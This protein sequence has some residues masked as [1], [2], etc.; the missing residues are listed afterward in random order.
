M[1]AVFSSE[2]ASLLT[3]LRPDHFIV[4]SKVKNSIISNLNIKNWPVHCFDVTGC[5][6]VT[7]SGLTLDNSDG[8][9]ANS[10]SD[11]DPAAHNSDGFDFSSS[12]NIYL[13]DT[14]V[15]NQDDCV[16][17]TSGV[18]VTV[19]NMVCS[20]GHGLSIGSI[21]GKSN[22]V[23]DGVTFQN[24]VIKNSQNGC[25]IKTNSGTTGSVSHIILNYHGVKLIVRRFR[26]SYTA[27]LLFQAL[28]STELMSSKITLTG[29]LL[30][31]Q[32]MVSL[33]AASHLK[34]SQAHVRQVVRTITFSVGLV[35]ARTLRSLES[36]LREA[37]L[38]AAA[39]THRLLVHRQQ[40]VSRRNYVYLVS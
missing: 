1:S 22:N 20:G 31:H 21:G 13:T 39:T 36:A 28:L 34:R 29:G 8:D 6:T 38:Q 24:S 18:N 7:F 15:T 30:A 14:T 26:M 40:R 33:L 2:T 9:A 12:N 4:V 17:V 16:A 27:I 32:Q 23:V 5:D 10:A 35:A 3:K 19:N 25:R 37:V 11:G